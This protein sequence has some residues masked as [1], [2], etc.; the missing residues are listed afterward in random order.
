MSSVF[1]GGQ[2]L[3][4]CVVSMSGILK[5][6]ISKRGGVLLETTVTFTVFLTQIH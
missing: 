2:A 6:F 5:L 3:H 1:W 4:A